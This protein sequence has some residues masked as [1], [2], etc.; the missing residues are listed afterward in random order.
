MPLSSYRWYRAAVI[1]IP[2]N[3]FLFNATQLTDLLFRLILCADQCS[4]NHGWHLTRELLVQKCALTIFLKLSAK[5][6]EDTS[7]QRHLNNS[8]CSSTYLRYLT[9]RALNRMVKYFF[10]GTLNYRRCTSL[11]GS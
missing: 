5:S 9:C 3:S 2:N 7:S 11:S 1:L 10:H 4:F 6:S 8:T